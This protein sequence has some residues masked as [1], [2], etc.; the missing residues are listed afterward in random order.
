M[1]APTIA[2]CRVGD[3]ISREP[4]RCLFPGNREL[5]DKIADSMRQDGYDPTWPIATWGGVVLDGHTRLA[6]ARKARLQVVPVAMHHFPDEAAAL[7]YAIRCQRNRRNLTAAELLRCL[8]ELDKRRTK[9][10]AGAMAHGELT[11][12]CVSSGASSAATAELLGVSARQ[13]EQLRTIA[14]HAP[15]PVKAALAAGGMSV[16]AAYEATQ[17]ARGR[18][19]PLPDTPE[20]AR[21]EKWETNLRAI[22]ER[23]PRHWWHTIADCMRN[24]AADL[25]LEATDAAVDPEDGA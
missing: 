23:F 5:V 3:L 14:D 22:A 16:N 1:D 9:A 12:D 4:F 2:A 10:E 24:V 18:K 20:P 19:R 25:D 13:V 6:A 17:G 7:E 21:I 15:E 8:E 11:Q